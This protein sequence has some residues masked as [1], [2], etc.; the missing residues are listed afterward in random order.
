MDCTYK[1]SHAMNERDTVISWESS[2]ESVVSISDNSLMVPKKVGS[3][4]ITATIST[5]DGQHTVD[6]ICFVQGR[7][8]LFFQIKFENSAITITGYLG[9]DK[10]VL[11]PAKISNL[12]V[13]EIGNYAFS[14]SSELE[15]ITIP[16]RVIGY[17]AFTQCLNLKNVF[18]LPGVTRINGSAFDN[19]RKLTSVTIPSG[20]TLIDAC[21]FS[22]CRAL[23]SVAIPS[24][25]TEIGDYAFQDCISLTSV[26]VESG[27]IKNSAFTRCT[28]LKEVM[29]S[30]GVTSIW[31][32]AFAFCTG[33]ETAV[34]SSQRIGCSAFWYCTSLKNVILST[35]VTEIRGG[36]FSDCTALTEITIPSSV[37]L[38]GSGTFDRCTGLQSITVQADSPPEVE[39]DAFERLK[40]G[41][42]IYVPS[43]SI[44]LYIDDE[45]WSY[46]E[47]NIQGY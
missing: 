28:G 3:A 40:Q 6:Y 17:D 10:D 35:D 21:A 41:L 45:F 2:D 9:S 16:S 24:S 32:D 20:V 42:A 25:V 12:S 30:S 26:S 11:I 1:L 43:I 4:I 33:L 39:G 29:I 5:E 7:S 44:D 14:S 46:Y 18:M 38:I 37:S 23:S 36:A 13:G 47:S 34:I 22:G 19:C 15:S 8:D 27:I 31:P